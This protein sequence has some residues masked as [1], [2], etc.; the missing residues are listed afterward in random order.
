VYFA[1]MPLPNNYGT[2]T[3]RYP[4]R[5]AVIAVAAGLLRVPAL[6]A[7]QLP[8]SEVDFTPAAQEKMQWYGQEVRA[9][10]QSAILVAVSREA[11]RAAVPPGLRVAIT[12]QDL[13]PTHP[14][15]QQLADDPTLDVLRT[16]YLGGA[17]LTGQ[18]RDV[19]QRVLTT[20]HYRHFPL[21]LKLGSRSSDP[22]ADARVAIDELA[23]RLAA[24]GRKLSVR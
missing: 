2:S 16:R 8:V 5:A 23:A 11:A 4:R 22:W 17:E 10:L 20:V 15:R 24:A 3:M 6:P 9:T 14:T 12:V 18:V 1:R 21:T 13:A 7:G 19:D